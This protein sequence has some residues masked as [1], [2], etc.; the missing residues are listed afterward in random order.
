MSN[1]RNHVATKI[2]AISNRIRTHRE[3]ASRSIVNFARAPPV[4]STPTGYS[5]DLAVSVNNDEKEEWPGPF[6]TANAML[7]KRDEVKSQRLAKISQMNEK[8]GDENDELQDEFDMKLKTLLWV[9]N[10]ENKKFINKNE[11]PS[12]VDICV[13]FIVSNFDSIDDLGN[14]SI[15][16]RERLSDKLGILRKF[17][18]P[19]ALILASPGSGLLSLTECSDLDENSIIKVSLKHNLHLV[20]D[21]IY[22][23]TA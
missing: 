17:N 12:L 21:V 6:S 11:I 9:P 1:K 3:A 23:F 13:N 10:T 4:S 8:L 16:V 7:Q 18:E 22:I 2:D 5:S 19:F 14:I 15:D 20:F